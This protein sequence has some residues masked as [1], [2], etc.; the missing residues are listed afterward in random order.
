VRTVAALCL[1]AL[2]I[3]GCGAAAKDSAKSFKGEE[4][5]VA[6]VVED[7][8]SAARKNKPD[9]VCTKLVDAKLLATLK[10]QGTVCK[11]AIK[12]AFEDADSFDL[13]VDDITINGASSTAKVTGGSGSDKKNYTLD[14]ARTGATWKISSLR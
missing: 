12:E 2:V 6:K 11:T 1:L 7:L 10:T 4:A 5:A 8:E 13:T 9:T 3:G 14:F